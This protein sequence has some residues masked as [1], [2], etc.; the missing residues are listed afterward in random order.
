MSDI[1]TRF[2]E[3]WLGMVQPI[4]GLVVS[5]PTLVDAQC[6]ERQTPAVQQRLLELCPEVDGTDARAIADLDALFADLLGLTPDLLD[7]GDALPAD[8]SLY[9]QE[10]GQI[11]RPTMALKRLPEVLDGD[12]EKSPLGP[13]FLKGGKE[14]GEPE[15]ENPV[16]PFKK[17]G[18]GG[19]SP[20]IDAGKDYVALVWTLPDALPFDRSESVT[21][22]WDY[23]PAA[24]F[25]RLLRHCR[26]P[27]GVLT[28]RRAVRLVY[29]PHGEASGAITFKVDDM[30]SPGGRPILDAF[31]M[32]LSAQR[33]FGVA[34]ERQLPALLADSRKR[35]A[36]VTNELAAQVFQALE[37]LLRGFQAA[38]ERDG[39][40]RLDDAARR[41]DDHLY[42]GLLTV[43][44]RLV[45]VLY[46]EDRDLLPVDDP[47][48]EEHLSVLGL[49]DQ[50]QNDFGA[51]PDSMA[52]R[53]GAWDRLIALFRAIYRGAV[54]H[55]FHMIPRRGQLF[56]PEEYPFLEGWGPGGSAPMKDPRERAT[57]RVP[58][59]DDLTVY[60]VLEKLIVFQGQRLSY[61]TLDIEQIGSVYEALM[62]YHVVR[63]FSPAV[64]LRPSRCW[65]EAREVLE[66]TASRRAK[67]LQET[68]GLP[69]AQ[70]RSLA[71]EL[72]AARTEDAVVAVLE[73]WRVKGTE[74]AQPDRLVVQPGAERRR[75]SSH[76]T[77]RSLSAPIVRRTLEPLLATMGPEPSSERLLQLKVC[78]PAMGSGAFLVEA[79]RFLGDQVVAA[80]TREKKLEKIADA[81]D[82]V[83][84]HARRL[85]AQR[86]LYG[87]DKNPF[88]VHLAKLS[89]WLETLARE[90]PFTFLDH[91]LRHGDS[92]VGLDFDQIRGFHWQG[93]EQQF[94][95]SRELD[96]ALVRAVELRQ[97]ILELAESDEPD[98]QREK[99]RL[100]ETAEVAVDNVRL[101]GDLVIGAF[102][103]GTNDRERKQELARRLTAVNLWLQ[104]GGHAPAE[105]REMQRELR[106][107]TPTFHW[108]LEFPE[109]FYAERPDPLEEGRVNRVAFFDAFIGNPPFLG[110]RRI[111]TQLGD[112]YSDWLSFSHDTGKN[113]DLC[114]HFFRKGDTLLGKHGVL[115]L[116]ATNTISQGDTRLAGLRPILK[117]GHKI[118]N[119]IRSFLWPGEA[120]VSVAIVHTA[121]GNP[122]SMTENVMLDESI[123]PQINS[124]LRPRAERD[125]PAVLLGNSG[126]S[127]QGSVVVGIG[128]ILDPDDRE[129]LVTRNKINRE[130]ILPY[131]GGEE[132]NT[133]PTHDYHRYVISF[134]DMDLAAASKWGD[135]IE[136][137]REK[138]K[139][140]RDRVK[141][142]AHRRY[143]WQ[144]GDKRPALYDA[145]SRVERCLVTA[146]VTKHLCFSFQP[147]DR[148]FNEKL[149]VFPLDSITHFAILQ[150]R[151][152]EV[153]VRLL[154]STL[155]ET[156]NYSATDCFDTYPFP[157]SDPRTEIP[158]LEAIGQR[159]YEARASYMV[160]TQQGLTQTYNHLKDPTCDDPRIAELRRLHEDMDRAVLAAYGWSDIEVPPYVTPATD[161]ERRRLEA[162]EDEVI[163]R[164]FVLN[165]ERAREEK[166]LGIR[167]SKKGG[168]KA[169][170]RRGASS[171]DQLS[172]L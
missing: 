167:A 87:V 88:A 5:V 66:Q 158:E 26:V 144:F 17:G 33:F 19:I 56:D 69:K 126:L 51:H 114:S 38:A 101:I 125:N 80:W 159:L 147:T 124:R 117:G 86:C 81:H 111:S 91:A 2:H 55:D 75:T 99:E 28:N 64:C 21:G 46:A 94:L 129:A 70:A 85:V 71:D 77:P 61:S 104:D 49:F 148:I 123:V 34:P 141:R 35:Q 16:P 107:T 1:E 50:L 67:W 68:T 168:I 13:P 122:A 138:V 4:D 11:L 22:P 100:L 27:I 23:P 63:V 10:G 146:R 120:T 163:D 105:L 137:V 57:V 43:L 102:F 108:M 45:F 30:A 156:L 135:L 96:A 74:T 150:S 157:Q 93:D 42:G 142:E 47:L 115:G 53:F 6:L 41:D 48:Y 162:F 37:T 32:L 40:Q 133:S 127:F 113:S 153:W 130:R 151:V 78:D 109:V 98:D 18:L 62:G 92:L 172:L 15:A 121:K 139:P 3:T 54:H 136:I 118:Y 36:N 169:R 170:K 106:G 154:S 171:D 160:D 164:L 89:L 97:Q 134:G 52:R 165:A 8:L 83:T 79:C 166:R 9:V 132:V 65:L 112:E 90:L 128:F 116:I 39:R 31:V 131:L 110:G 7:A 44:L 145:L 95:C 152:H 103:A 149:F 140:E 14:D 29:A 24:K 76:Y 155:G 84:N 60:R 119:A 20:A 25:D 143:W 161:A 72:A 58:T 82:D 12:R 73:G 59:I